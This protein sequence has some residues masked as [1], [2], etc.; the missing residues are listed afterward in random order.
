MTFNNRHRNLSDFGVNRD[1]MLYIREIHIDNSF[2]QLA[3]STRITKKR[4]T[5]K[6]N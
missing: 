3:R 6:S 1:V 2:D 5:Q 4:E